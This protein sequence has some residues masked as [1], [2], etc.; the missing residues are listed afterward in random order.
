MVRVLEEEPAGVDASLTILDDAA[1]AV[2]PRRHSMPPVMHSV[3]LHRD[4]PNGD[5]AGSQ[6]FRSGEWGTP[7][8]HDRNARASI[9]SMEAKSPHLKQSLERAISALS[10]QNS[11]INELK[12]TNQRL[13]QSLE[14]KRLHCL[15]LEALL[16]DNAKA[17][18]QA[19]AAVQNASLHE[20]AGSFVQAPA[21]PTL[22]NFD[23]ST[24][25]LHS[26]E[27]SPEPSPR[28]ASPDPSSARPAVVGT[29]SGSTTPADAEVLSEELQQPEAPSEEIQQGGESSAE[30]EQDGAASAEVEQEGARRRKKESFSEITLMGADG[31][32]AFTLSPVNGAVAEEEQREQ[33][34]QQHEQQPTQPLPTVIQLASLQM[35]LQG[36][37]CSEEKTK[38]EEAEEEEDERVLTRFEH[39]S[40]PKSRPWD[41]LTSKAASDEAPELD[42]HGLLYLLLRPQHLFG[43]HFVNRRNHIAKYVQVKSIGAAFFGIFGL[44]MVVIQNELIIRDA[45]P[46][47]GGVTALKFF[48][49][50]ATILCLVLVFHVHWYF[51]LS[52]RMDLHTKLG[53]PFNKTGIVK[54]ILRRWSYWLETVLCSIHLPPGCTFAFGS[55]NMGNFVLYRAEALDFLVCSVRL[56]LAFRVFWHWMVSDLPKKHIVPLFSSAR[57][58][59][60]FALKR[61]FEGW[62]AIKF[63]TVIWIA[64]IV[65]AGYFFRL[66]EMSACVLASGHDHP[67]CQGENAISWSLDAGGSYFDVT[68]DLYIWNSF[69]V[70]FITSIT[71]GYGDL[72]PVTHLGRFVAVLSALL[73]IVLASVLTA[74]LE[75]I[76]VFSSLEHSARMHMQGA[77]AREK[78][79][80][81]AAVYIG[82]WC[83][84]HMTRKRE[85]VRERSGD[86][87]HPLTLSRQAFWQCKI[88]A[89]KL[90]RE[91]DCS[92][93]EDKVS[94]ALRRVM[95]MDAVMDRMTRRLRA[96]VGSELATHDRDRRMSKVS[97][98]SQD[99]LPMP[100]GGER[101]A[102]LTRVMGLLGS[103]QIG[104]KVKHHR[105]IIARQGSDWRMNKR[106]VEHKAVR[107]AHSASLLALSGLVC[108]LIVNELIFL[109]V[110]PHAPSVE[111][112]KT[113][114]MLVSL[115][116]VPVLYR[117]YAL[118][119]L[120]AR[121]VRARALAKLS[122]DR[123]HVG[124]KEVLSQPPFWLESLV[125]AVHLPPGV[126]F[127]LGTTQ[128]SNFVMYRGE[129][130]MFMLNLARCYLLVRV[131]KDHV[132]SHMAHLHSIASVHRIHCGY[133][134][135]AKHLHNSS[136]A[137]WYILFG[138]LTSIVLL[139]FLTRAAEFPACD[140]K[141]STHPKC[142]TEQVWEL[143][144]SEIGRDNFRYYQ[145]AWWCMFVTG[146]TVGYG[147]LYPVTHL[148]RGFAGLSAVAG[149]LATSLLTAALIKAL[150]RTSQE[151]CAFN[152]L[153]REKAIERVPAIAA[154]I[155]ARAFRH[156]RK[157]RRLREKIEAGHGFVGV[158]G[159]QLVLKFVGWDENL[160]QHKLFEELRYCQALVAQGP[161]EMASTEVQVDLLLKGVMRLSESL[162]GALRAVR[163]LQRQ[164]RSKMEA[165]VHAQDLSRPS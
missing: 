13:M 9:E 126:T 128:L 54:A 89:E 142:Q 33:Q 47:S 3:N 118:R 44:L 29:A 147:D 159:S 82:V 160:R 1:K 102:S 56:Y 105:A 152:F 129:T 138:W 18:I 61:C 148:G 28:P 136:G 42:K 78:L 111:V 39:N 19:N 141:H 7:S 108:S 113:L 22:E 140:L 17:I 120:L 162:E 124:I 139:A 2:T 155:I 161:E 163:A 46:L 88:E 145:N 20:A 37:V 26:R 57:V 104:H 99:Q 146:T 87:M 75:S 10:E 114:N 130:L 143:Y 55:T 144:G 133:R 135:V 122:P 125:C 38:E 60:F 86:S 71:V 53:Y 112:L 98:S 117:S 76:L 110:S 137:S 119:V 132:L 45:S 106:L 92:S 131:V 134:F 81:K 5:G 41:E 100:T 51:V 84:A 97:I 32:P 21:E 73:G 70:M 63:I 95:Y 11:V 101:R 94:K 24:M 43:V 31:S 158:A 62:Q 30:V 77:K 74:S 107:A 150:T 6:H 15:R 151:D 79:Q 153:R 90:S 93:V 91:D 14:E 69:W 58:G 52:D 64:V 49:T 27:A 116:S 123:L 109:D 16:R 72:Y 156:K 12:Q 154:S 8:D 103:M 34:Q 83:R 48:N 127:E 4:A 36:E 68:Q 157:H 96:A 149:V 115:G 66:S 67:G 35:H 80:H 23:R 85:E 121:L 65:I 59:P 25:L 164:A 50:L 165:P 40:T